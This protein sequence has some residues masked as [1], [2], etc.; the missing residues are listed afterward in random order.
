M[1]HQQGVQLNQPKQNIDFIF[2][3]NNN[4]HQIHNGSLEFDVT[5]PKSDPT[6]FH[7]DDLIG[8]LINA[9]AFCFT[10]PRSSSTFG[11]DIEHNKFC[12]QVSTIMK[13]ILNR[14][15]DLLSQFDNINE[16]E[17]PILQRLADLAPQ[18]RDT[19]Q[20]KMLINNHTDRKKGKLKGYLYL[21]D[22]FGFR[23]SFK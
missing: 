8:L 12:G 7:N 5:V 11:S 3:E 4:Y 2:G 21:E 22:L 17:I 15:G 13:T 20:Q 6:N 9:Y 14:G 1:Y 10:E 19:P 16:K 23:K 18:I